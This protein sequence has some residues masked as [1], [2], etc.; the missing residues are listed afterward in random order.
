MTLGQFK[1]ITKLDAFPDYMLKDVSNDTVLNVYSNGEINYKIKNI[2]AKVSVIWNYQ[3][4]EGTGDT[5]YS[6]MRGTKS[7]LIIKQGE[8]EQYKP[9][10][11]I[12]PLGNGKDFEP[13]LVNQLVT[14]Q[15]KFPGIG[16]SKVNDMWMITIPDEYKE[17]HE[18]HFG[19]VTE[20]FLEYLDKH[21]MP[22]WEVPNMIAKY[23]TTTKAL[24]MAKN[25]TPALT[26]R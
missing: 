14:L 15:S 8:E 1:A 12:Q 21:N 13:M 26:S 2:H 18:A 6:I 7:N 25:T 23:Y 17:G 24:E 11:Y 5:H 4:P 3:A 19:R 16:M 10:L 22:P 20:K 9:T